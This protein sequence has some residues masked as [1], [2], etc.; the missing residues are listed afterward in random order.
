MTPTHN[1]LDITPY[2]LRI[3][4]QIIR[5]DVQIVLCK[6]LE[7]LY[8]EI[9]YYLEHLKAKIDEYGWILLQIEPE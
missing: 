3:S 5:T 6:G 2:L 8:S 7:A 4:S 1:L 9:Q